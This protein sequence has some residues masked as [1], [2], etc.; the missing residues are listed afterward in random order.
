MVL[1]TVQQI[2]VNWS[3]L[4]WKEAPWCNPHLRKFEFVVLLGIHVGWFNTKISECLAVILGTDSYSEGWTPI[5]LLN[6]S[7]RLPTLPQT[8][9]R[10]LHQVTGDSS[11]ILDRVDGCWMILVYQL[12]STLSHTS[13]R[14]VLA[15]RK[16][17]E[18]TSP[19]SPGCLTHQIATLLIII[20]WVP[21]GE[22]STKLQVMPNRNWRQG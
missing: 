16:S 20:R 10:C 22:S 11:A 2:R 7:V 14:T 12:N 1:S 15:V 19:L 6:I 21:L 8:Q 3:Q 5:S 17:S 4:V 13:K 9:H 18:T